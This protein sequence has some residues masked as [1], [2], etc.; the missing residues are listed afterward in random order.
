MP[1]YFLLP[2][3]W[4]I[5]FIVFIGTF[6]QGFF[7]VLRSKYF[8]LILLS[9]FIMISLYLFYS[10]FVHGFLLTFSRRWLFIG[11]FEVITEV[12][13]KINR[14]HNYP[15][16]AATHR[17]ALTAPITDDSI[18]QDQA[19]LLVLLLGVALHS[20]IENIIINSLLTTE[21]HHDKYKTG[22]NPIFLLSLGKIWFF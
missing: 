15:K 12:I 4:A 9:H 21:S 3:L 5:F 10:F 14:L 1:L 19:L 11:V 20:F 13:P 17:T 16:N 6:L 22:M 18:W 8:P 2:Y 7:E